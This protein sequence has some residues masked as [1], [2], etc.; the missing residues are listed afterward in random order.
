MLNKTEIQTLK[1]R[2]HHLKPVVLIGG[3]GL[4]PGVLNEL[5]ISL[6]HHELMKIRVL[7]PTREERKEV[8]DSICQSLGATVINRIGHMVLLYRPTATAESP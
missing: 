2:G 3:K 6:E 8:I 1:Q 4:T 5:N 7:R